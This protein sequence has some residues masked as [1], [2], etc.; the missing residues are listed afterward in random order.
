LETQGEDELISV[1]GLAALEESDLPRLTGS[2]VFDERQDRAPQEG[3]S[4]EDRIMSVAY[5]RSQDPNPLKDP[6]SPFAVKI[7]IKG[8]E[9]KPAQ[10][11]S[12]NELVIPARVGEEFS[13]RIQNRNPQQYPL[14]C[15]RLLVDGLNTLP[16]NLVEKGIIQEKWGQRVNLDVARAW[17]LDA[18]DSRVAKLDGYPT[19]E[20]RG[21]VKETGAQGTLGA[22][23]FTDVERSLAGRQGF[24]EG[25]G[26]ITAAFYKPNGTARSIGVVDGREIVADLTPRKGVNPGN[27]IGVYNLRYVEASAVGSQQR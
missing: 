3:T 21:F 25:I 10:G 7:M 5:R 11:L 23:T 16:D 4:S 27:L 12:P 18:N 19:W 9:R 17:I 15:M 14:V 6:R 2:F 8:S 24:T 22:F 26:L 20:V 13:I 1:G